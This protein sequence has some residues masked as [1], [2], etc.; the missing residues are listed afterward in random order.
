MALALND[1]LNVEG[2]KTAST[3][4]VEKY[5]VEVITDQYIGTFDGILSSDSRS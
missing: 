1:S 3:S 4:Q 2:Q 5:K